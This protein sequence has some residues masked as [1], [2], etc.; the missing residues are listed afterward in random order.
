MHLELPSADAAWRARGNI[1][2]VNGSYK[3]NFVL[4][5]VIRPAPEAAAPREAVLDGVSVDRQR[6]PRS[7]HRSPPVRR[8]NNITPTPIELSGRRLAACVARRASPG[9]RARFASCAASS[10]FRRRARSSRIRPARSTSPRTTRRVTPRSTSRAMRPTTSTSRARSTRSRCR[11]P[12]R[13]SSRVGPP[14][15]DRLRQIADARPARPRPQPR[16]AP[17]L[18]RRSTSIGNDPTRGNT[19]TN[20]SGGVGDQL[21]RDLAGDWV[22]S[23]LGN[24][25]D[26]HHPGRRAAVR[27]RLWLR[28]RQRK[29]EGVREHR[30]P[31]R[32]GAD[33]AR[34]HAQCAWRRC[35]FRITWPI[36]VIT[37][38]RFTLQGGYLD[39]NYNNPA[40]PDMQDVQAK[41]VYRLF[42]P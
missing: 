20:P 8:Q 16:A 12:A 36:K 32:R 10:R 9:C 17:P 34:L 5:E 11:S 31:R 18:A 38:D 2:I 26:E 27:D 3:R 24:S 7:Q 14:H 29:E 6:R 33:G 22:S 15:V 30:D 28:R 4:T 35:R 23:L 1:A 19:S 39:K 25:L 42:I 13:S 40:E 21:V 37:D 41:L